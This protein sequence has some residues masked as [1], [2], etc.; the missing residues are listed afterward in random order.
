MF[1]LNTGKSLSDYTAVTYQRTIINTVTVT[2]VA[3]SGFIARD[4]FCSVLI[5]N[6]GVKSQNGVM[7]D[8][9]MSCQQFMKKQFVRPR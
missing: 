6:T 5:N 3:T 9:L 8:I 2:S 4:C 1:L 7:K